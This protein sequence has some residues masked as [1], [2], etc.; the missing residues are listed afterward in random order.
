MLLGMAKT[1]SAPTPKTADLWTAL[2]RLET[3]LNIYLGQKA[4]QL[5]KGLKNFIVW[6]APYLTILGVIVTLLAVV[7]LLFLAL[8]MSAL[9]APFMYADTV[10]EWGLFGIVGLAGMIV[11]LVLS[12][13]AIPGLFK[14]LRTAWTKLFW[15]SLV[16]IVV[17]VFSGNFFGTAISALINWYILFQIRS[18]Y[19]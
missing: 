2:S 19:K 7:P 9:L 3:W 12:I 6:I 17:G 11:T 10:W 5:P 15:I 18:V 16:N 1:K 4:P 8:G 13:Q 14:R